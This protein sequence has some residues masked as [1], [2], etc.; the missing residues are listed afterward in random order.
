MAYPN[1]IWVKIHVPEKARLDELQADQLIR[2]LTFEAQDIAIDKTY[3]VDE[4]FQSTLNKFG[5][6]I[7]RSYGID[8]GLVPLVNGKIT[9]MTMTH[10]DPN[11]FIHLIEA[12]AGKY[13][14]EA[15]DND[16]AVCDCDSYWVDD[17]FPPCR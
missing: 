7:Y 2:E 6:E 15:V 10:E 5:D 12:I 3:N 16:V 1:Y 13:C 17:G 8:K 11:D 14:C 4:D 9:V